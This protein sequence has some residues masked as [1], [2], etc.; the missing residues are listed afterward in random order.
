VL[1]PTVW[2]FF[3]LLGLVVAIVDSDAAAIVWLAAALATCCIA[4][5]VIMA[6]RHSP[7]RSPWPWALG[8]LPAALLGPVAFLLLLVPPI[9]HAL[10]GA[11]ARRP[12]WDRPPA[13]ER[14]VR[15]TTPNRPP[16]VPAAAAGSSGSLPSEKLVAT[17][18]TKQVLTE[19][20]R[21][22]ARASRAEDVQ[23]L[24]VILGL[25]E[26]IA[27]GAED[28]LRARA[29]RVVSATRQNIR[30][31]TRKYALA[32]GER[33]FDPFEPGAPEPVLAAPPAATELAAPV[34]PKPA[35]T[36]IALLIGSIAAGAAAFIALFTFIVLGGG[37]YTGP[38]SGGHY[39][40]PHSYQVLLLIGAGMGAAGVA[41]VVLSW[42]ESG[43]T[44]QR[45][46]IALPLAA[47]ALA[48]IAGLTGFLWGQSGDPRP[49]NVAPPK[50]S[51]SARVGV[52]MK[53][54]EGVWDEHGWT[55]ANDCLRRRGCYV[56]SVAWQRCDPRVLSCRTIRGAT[57]ATEL[58]APDLVGYRL[59]VVITAENDAGS[60]SA[61]SRPTAVVRG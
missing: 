36:L 51:G 53:A 35:L 50:I 22:R 17:G 59:R 28:N 47:V 23:A 5:A 6:R 49:A 61:R 25:G 40:Y 15:P 46:A 9:R 1:L 32:R 18:E 44:L 7:E 10:T 52:R 16:A 48:S 13:P 43:T 14:L 21:A 33:W 12:V 26:E 45:L 27:D 60:R 20:E 31:V 30:S 54:D 11:L 55:P 34:P 8:S 42:L 4:I 38:K 41:A 3:L 29:D 56:F 57:G 19:L 58:V 24:T 37:D 39:V 2:G